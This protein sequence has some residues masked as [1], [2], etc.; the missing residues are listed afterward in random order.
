MPRLDDVVAEPGI[1]PE[2]WQVEAP[3]WLGGSKPPVSDSPDLHRVLNLPR[4]SPVEVNTATATALIEH[5]TAKYGRG[6]VNCRCEQIQDAR[7]VR[8]KPCIKTPNYAQAWMLHELHINAGLIAN[9]VVGIGKTFVDILA[10]L[11]MPD[12][13]TALLLVPP[14]LIPQLVNEYLLVREHW[15]V[16]TVTWYGVREPTQLGESVSLHVM[17]Y[18]KLSGEDATDLLDNRLQ[19]DAIFADE[20]HKISNVSSVRGGRILRAFGQH[21][22]RIRFGCWSGTLTGD[23]LLDYWHLALLALRRKAP[24]PVDQEVAKEWAA[25]IDPDEWTAPPGA[26]LEFCEPGEHVQDGFHRRLAE[27][28]G[29]VCTTGASIDIDL[30]ID[31]R[32]PPPIPNVSRPDPRAPGCVDADLGINVPKGMWPGLD[33]ALRFLRK[34]WIRPDGEWLLDAL[35]ASRCARELACGLFLRWKFI[36][37]ETREQVDEWKAARKEWRAEERE[38]LKRRIPHMDSPMLLANAAMRAW[39]TSSQFADLDDE[40]KKIHVISAEKARKLPEWRAGT[41]PRWAKIKDDVR[42][43]TEV[44]RLDDYLAQDA[45]RW[46]RENLGIIWYSTVGFGAWIAEISGLPQHGGGPDAGAKIAKEKGDRSIVASLSSHGTGRDGLQLLFSTQ[47]VTQPPSSAEAWEQAIGRLARINQKASCVTADVYRHTIEL[48]NFVD[49]ALRRA[50]YVQRTMRAD[51][52]LLI[53]WQL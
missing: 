31:E 47:L 15:K 50:E 40:G 8:R 22:S 6:E 19:P 33:D 53:G 25:A 51:Q 3:D 32:I 28:P 12:C 44:V 24:V 7:G 30:K 46:G 17:S 11:A 42:P 26:L 16:P 14:T 13:K 9:A 1:R 23:S 39:K 38:M 27:T 20:C 5:I 41:W 10:P 48:Q 21:G 4:R 52:K 29:F 37:G 45:A 18:N 35:S 49:S 36:H 2:E 34:N 43:V